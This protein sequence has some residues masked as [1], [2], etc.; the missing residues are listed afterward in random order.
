MKRRFCNDAKLI[1]SNVDRLFADT[2]KHCSMV[3]CWIPE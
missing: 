3:K 1:P 2:S